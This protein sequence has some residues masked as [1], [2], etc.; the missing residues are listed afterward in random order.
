VLLLLLK[1]QLPHPLAQELQWFHQVHG[2]V[3]LLVN[4]K[5]TP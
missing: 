1:P 4:I 5:F 2:M 3:R